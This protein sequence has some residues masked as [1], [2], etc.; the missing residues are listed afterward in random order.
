MTNVFFVSIDTTDKAGLCFTFSQANPHEAQNCKQNLRI[1]QHLKTWIPGIDIW[2]QF[3][4]HK[5]HVYDINFEKEK[6]NSK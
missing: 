5:I 2:K 4:R 3:W 6:N 1:S